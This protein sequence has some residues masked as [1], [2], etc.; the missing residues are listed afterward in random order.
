MR[1]L[2]GTPQEAL[3]H[4][5]TGGK[6]DRR[7]NRRRQHP[8][9]PDDRHRHTDHHHQP[10]RATRPRVDPDPGVRQE[11]HRARLDEGPRHHRGLDSLPAPRNIHPRGNRQ[12]R[13]R[14]K[15]TR[16][17][18]RRTPRTSRR[19]ERPRPAS[20]RD[21]HS[22]GNRHHGLRA[23]AYRPPGRRGRG[24]ARRRNSRR[25]PHQR[26]RH[27]DIPPPKK[28]LTPSTTQLL[29]VQPGTLR[30]RPTTQRGHR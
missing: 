16:N 7:R 21:N 13:P 2:P 1:M 6:Q 9:P 10:Q 28:E 20:R 27:P 11:V 5:H 29:S 15:R 22:H 25:H 24:K 23:M 17:D 19:V 14:R 12:Q 26:I 8:H 18:L 4:N 3:S 30:A